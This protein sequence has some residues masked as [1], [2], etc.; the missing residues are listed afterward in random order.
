[1]SIL[2]S[3]EGTLQVQIVPANPLYETTH[4]KTWRNKIPLKR[5]KL[6][7]AISRVELMPTI[8]GIFAFISVRQYF[9]KWS[10]S[11]NLE[12]HKFNIFIRY[13]IYHFFWKKWRIRCS[14]ST[15]LDLYELHI[16]FSTNNIYPSK[17]TKG[18]CGKRCSIFFPCGAFSGVTF[19][20]KIVVSSM[21]VSQI[22]HESD[23]EQGLGRV[24]KCRQISAVL[25]VN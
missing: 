8:I 9:Q 5:S 1:M 6:L 2:W 12:Y 11:Q 7:H 17:A 13:F 14:F 3:A 20:F 21:K 23:W 25:T 24:R 22:W 18:M 19:T 15:I 16:F 4:D 10:K